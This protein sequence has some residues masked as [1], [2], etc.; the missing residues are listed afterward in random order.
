MRGEK[1]GGLA[2]VARVVVVARIARA[3]RGSACRAL[4]A[5]CAHE[6]SAVPVSIALVTAGWAYRETRR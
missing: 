4:E 1:I 3:A 2:V 5:E 6:R